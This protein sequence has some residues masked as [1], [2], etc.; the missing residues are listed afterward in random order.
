M[1]AILATHVVRRA[2]KHRREV[3]SAW[4]GWSLKAF[5]GWGAMLAAALPSMGVLCCEFVAFEAGECHST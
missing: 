3:T 1:L 5:G 4:D 2:R